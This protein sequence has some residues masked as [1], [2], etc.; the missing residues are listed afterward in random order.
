MVAVPM[1][2][3]E[4]I[5]GGKWGQCSAKG[6]GEG[7]VRQKMKARGRPRSILTDLTKASGLYPKENGVLLST[8]QHDYSCTLLRSC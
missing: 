8:G 4:G 3:F 1:S 2:R 5:N 6:R 7:G